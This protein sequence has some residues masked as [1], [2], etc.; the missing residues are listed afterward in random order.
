MYKED[1]K[2]HTGDKQHVPSL[3]AMFWVQKKNNPITTP[4]YLKHQQATV[5]CYIGKTVFLRLQGRSVND[6]KHYKVKK[7]KMEGKGER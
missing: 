7:R 4:K 5:C 3:Y 2:K 1:T 6:M